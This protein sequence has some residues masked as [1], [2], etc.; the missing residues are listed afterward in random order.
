MDIA[1]I[2]K[3]LGDDSRLRLL[4][5]LSKG[6]FNVQELT[7]T[8]Q[9]SQS[10]I[11]HHLKIL[12][13]SGLVKHRKEGSW[14]F[15]TIAPSD[16][17]SFEGQLLALTTDAIT[18]SVKL[19][20]LLEEDTRAIEQVLSA[21]RDKGRRYFDTVAR[22]WGEIRDEAQGKADYLPCL[23]EMISST[24]SLLELGCGSG[25]VL[26]ELMPRQGETF[27]VDY[28]NAM[29]EEAREN[30]KQHT[31]KIDLRLGY[32]EHLPIGDETIDCAIA[33]MVFHHIAE[34]VEA[35]RDI[36]RVLRSDGKLIVVDLVEHNN[37]YMRDRYADLWL[38]FNTETFSK[39]GAQLGLKTEHIEVLGQEKDVF[40]IEMTKQ[41]RE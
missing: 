29:I 40:V 37:E 13:Q 31:S 30:L 18:R 10:T 11:S 6:S 32:L 24:D 34:P 7:N 23:K 15:Y 41:E 38:G 25:T 3:A 39:W 27:G 2:L 4:H 33:C 17:T 26:K 35:L 28:S 8:L 16:N 19:L 22:D 9:L 5:L 36:T 21:R 14:A 1:G 12:E 20:Q